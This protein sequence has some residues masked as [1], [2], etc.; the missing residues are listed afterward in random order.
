ML[1]S[2][3]SPL[4]YVMM[5]I[6]GSAEETWFDSAA[7]FESDCSDEEFQSVTDGMFFKIHTSIDPLVLPSHLVDGRQ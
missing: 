5:L 3:L 1:G 2:Q 7:V 6:S 4:L